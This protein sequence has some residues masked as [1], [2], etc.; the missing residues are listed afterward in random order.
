[1]LPAQKTEKKEVPAVKPILAERVPIAQT[2]IPVDNIKYVVINKKSTAKPNNVK[3]DYYSGKSSAK[4]KYKTLVIKIDK[5]PVIDDNNLASA[6]DEGQIEEP[7]ARSLSYQ[8]QAELY[9]QLAEKDREQA[10]KNRKQAEINRIQ[11]QKDREQAVKDM[12][13]ASLD[14]QHAEKDRQQAEEKIKLNIQEKSFK[15][16]HL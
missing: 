8:Q 15:D 7:E 2:K 13:Q 4:A 12:K 3:A 10:S 1:M 9:R 16:A 14:R 5:K 11:S 6:T